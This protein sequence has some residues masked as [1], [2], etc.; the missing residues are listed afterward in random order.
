ML[1][2]GNDLDTNNETTFA[3]REQI[4]N[5]QV[6]VAVTEERL[7]KQT[8]SHGKDWSTKMNCVFYVAPTKE[9]PVGQV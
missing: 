3:T 5:K 1:V 6:Y 7:R 8:R 2:T 4:P 9:L